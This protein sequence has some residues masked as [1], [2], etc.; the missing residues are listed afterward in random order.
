[1]GL[2][3]DEFQAQLADLGL[4]IVPVASDG[5]C[6]FREIAHQ[7]E[8]DEEEHSRYREMVVEYIMQ[9]REDFEPFIEDNLNFGEYCES[10]KKSGTWAG[11]MEIQAASLLTRTNI[12]IHRLSSPK[13]EI[14]NFNNRN[15]RTLHLSYHE[16][17]HYNSAVRLDYDSDDAALFHDFPSR[18][19]TAILNLQLQQRSNFASLSGYFFE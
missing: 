5:N 10:M 13:L 9:H 18:S 3:R 14:K 17:R 15:V 6:F 2:I 16:R 11:H 19:A 12:C 8:G 7:I 4:R 1:M